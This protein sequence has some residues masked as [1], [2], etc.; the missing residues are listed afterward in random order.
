MWRSHAEWMS[1]YGTEDYR[2]PLGIASLGVMVRDSPVRTKLARARA[3]RVPDVTGVLVLGL[4]TGLA[5]LGHQF[6]DRVGVLTWAVVLG[7]AA[8]NLGAVSVATA[9]SFAIPTKRLLRAGVVLLGFSLPIATVIDLGLPI[10]ALVA[11]TLV[12]TLSFT[13]W[14]GIRL[15]L[16]RSRSL[17]I[18]T[19]FAIC[20]ASAV[21]A[22]KDH[23]R[24]DEEDVAAAIAMVTL[25]GTV[26][27]VVMPLLGDPLGLSDRQFG[28]WAGASVHEVGQV[29]GAASAVGTAAVG[30]AVAVKLTRVLLL[31]PAVAVVGL[32]QRREAR[33]SG[34]STVNVPPLV[35]LFVLGF[36]LC[37]AVRS[38]GWLPMPL[39][40]AIEVV[41]TVT[42]AAALFGM[43]TAVHLRSLLRNAGPALVVAGGIDADDRRHESARHRV[44]G[45]NPAANGSAMRSPHAHMRKLALSDTSGKRQT[46]RC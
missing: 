32:V 4:G 42:L 27:M 24:A 40:H 36:I 15:G 14:L 3:W 33:R 7:V 35:P 2:R 45:L 5:Y 11:V 17:L 22:V 23:A 29:V 44:V 28:T 6:V 31:A 46:E 18:G 20:G 39:V 1:Q 25:C 38:S 9:N 26:A 41:Q 30:V 34:E 37:V 21:A 13:T 19:G 10:L 12:A 8:A 16:G 43:G